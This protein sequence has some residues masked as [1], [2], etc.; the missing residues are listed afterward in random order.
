MELID[1]ARAA[2]ARLTPACEMLG[3]SQRTYLRWTEEGAVRVD[4]RPEVVRPTPPHALSP[5]E[6]QEVLD[7]CH[8]PAHADLPPAQIVAR[9]LDEDGRY[10][11][12]ESTF[13]RI[14]R[15]H[16]EQHR[17]GRA[18]AP[19]PQARPTSYRADAPCQV[20]TWDVTW[21]AGPA[22][23]TFYYLFLILDLFSRKIVGWEVE[24]AETAAAAARVVE[25]AV[26]A[27]NCV[28]H[29]LVLH[30][31]NG[32]PLKG[33]TLLETLRR[34]EIEPSFSRPR[35]SDDNAFSEALFR[36]CKYVPDY[37]RDGFADLEAAR[38]WVRTFADWYN[39]EH[40]HSALRHVTPQQ[41]HD[42]SEARILAD[43]QRVYD[44]ARAQQPARWSGATRAW[45][46]V[47]S[48]WLNPERDPST[49]T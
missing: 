11:A 36:T 1:E 5:A 4:R 20:W 42:G 25:R 33:A 10:I 31:D 35:V 14:L 47:G 34:L 39:H 44:Q 23:G 16:H 12:S 45:T 30:A 27:E 17:R 49:D 9:L 26:L 15:R 38:G 24:E 22:R 7:A 13:Y 46:P 48:V 18:R 28:D 40:R 43:R 29:P 37:P 8:A 2:G 41:R 32:S 6:V 19:V 21:L 3:L